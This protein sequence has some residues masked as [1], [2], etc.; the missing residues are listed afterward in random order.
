MVH[1]LSLDVVALLTEKFILYPLGLISVTSLLQNSVGRF[2]SFESKNIILSKI[3]L[4]LVN[5]CLLSPPVIQF[6]LISI[7]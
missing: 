3:T 1:S 5:F 2:K 7:L 6:V 4:V